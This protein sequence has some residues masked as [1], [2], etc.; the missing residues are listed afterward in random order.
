[1]L[2][3]Y[4]ILL[5]EWAST[6]WGPMILIA[7][8]YLE[9]FV[10]PLPH[11]PILMTVALADPE[12]S[13]IYATMSSLASALGLTTGYTIGRLTRKT[14]IAGKIRANKHFIE[15]ETLINRYHRWATFIACFTPIP[16]KL[17]CAIAGLMKL[18]FKNFILIGLLARAC[19]F[20]L[21]GGLIYFFGEPIRDWILHSMKT[22]LLICAVCGVLLYFSTKWFYRFLD[23]KLQISNTAEK[24]KA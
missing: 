24:T 22:F 11:D 19:R 21:V 10:L 4:F 5:M 23:K 16:D 15:I 6:P 2:E 9:S 8:S 14:R 1:M 12:R 13:F 18:D 3:K 20:F 7:H 17:Y